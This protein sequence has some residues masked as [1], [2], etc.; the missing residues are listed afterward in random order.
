MSKLRDFKIIDLVSWRKRQLLKKALADAGG[1]EITLD[2]PCGD[3]K[4]W[5]AFREQVVG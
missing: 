2:L 3:G 5:S 4:F 1:V